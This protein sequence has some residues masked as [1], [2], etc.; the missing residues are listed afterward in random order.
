M[1]VFVDHKLKLT[2]DDLREIPE[3]DPYRHEIID[4][5]HVASPS[6]VRR[7]QYVSK[8]L[9]Y[10]LYTLI[11]LAGHG[12]MYAA[13]MDVELGRYDVFEPDLLV[14]LNHN[15]QIM[16]ESHIRG[17]PDLAVEILSPS[18]ASRDRGIKR[19][20]Y[21]KAGIPEYWVVDANKNQ[22]EVHVLD[23]I[24]AEFRAPQ[25]ARESLEYRFSTGAV[26]IDLTQVW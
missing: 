12:E 22:V 20:R 17:V 25:V 24:T 7:H 5:M 9:Q 21:E 8:R 11:E 1:P 13:P 10:Q 2:Y 6:P 4:G 19:E 18:T 15:A 23:P 14:I 3:D 16:E 26:T